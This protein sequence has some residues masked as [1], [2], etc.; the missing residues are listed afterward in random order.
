MV[1]NDSGPIR[2]IGSKDVQNILCM[3][4]AIKL[5]SVAFSSFSNKE[6]FVPPRYVADIPGKELISM[7]LV[8]LNLTCRRLIPES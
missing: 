1:L 8:L 6:C 5:M 2:I 4:D 7:P 3:K